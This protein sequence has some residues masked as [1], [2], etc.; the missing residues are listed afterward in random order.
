MSTPVTDTGS[1]L[2]KLN[3][4]PRPELVKQLQACLDVPRWA[5]DIADQRP[6]SSTRELYAA[7]DEAADPLSNE[8][9]HGALAAHPRIGERTEG[10]GSFSSSE[11][12]GVD[13]SDDEL[14]RALREGNEEYER[15]FGHV[16]LVCASGRG[17]RELLEILRSRLDNDPETEIDVVAAEL[18]KIA[19]LRLAKVIEQ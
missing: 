13:T 6:F 2:T 19:R 9:I 12:S 11:Q 7:A 18:R 16:Y 10:A 15:R 3:G 17:G 1:G 5:T 14:T 4:L 8:E